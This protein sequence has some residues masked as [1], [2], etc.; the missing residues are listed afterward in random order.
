M[1]IHYIERA[2]RGGREG[3]RVGFIAVSPICLLGKKQSA[4][5][6][7]RETACVCSFTLSWKVTRLVSNE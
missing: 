3:G 4:Q 6:D 2:S 1:P 7:R 5:Q